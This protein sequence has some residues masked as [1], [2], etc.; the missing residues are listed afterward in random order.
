MP[1]SDCQRG[2]YGFP[3]V[4]QTSGCSGF[5]IS[6]AYTLTVHELAEAR[7]NGLRAAPRLVAVGYTREGL[8]YTELA[9]KFPVDSEPRCAVPKVVRPMPGVLCACRKA[10]TLTACTVVQYG[11]VYMCVPRYILR[12]TRH[13]AP[14][15][16]QGVPLA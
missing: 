16:A 12:K 13:V 14:C 7:R 6:V 3:Q 9:G 15:C 1:V 10:G 4:P 2:S 8:D 11:D 5:S